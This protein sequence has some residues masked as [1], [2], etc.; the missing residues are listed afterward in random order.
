[1]R[2]GVAL[3]GLVLATTF[4][5]AEDAAKVTAEKLRPLQGIW[6]TQSFESKDAKTDGGGIRIVVDG[7][8]ISIPSPNAEKP[9]K[10]VALNITSDPMRIDFKFDRD[11]G[12]IVSQGIF[13]IEGDVL[14]VCSYDGNG[15][16]RP[17]EFATASDR[18]HLAI[19]KR[20]RD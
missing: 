4:V 2:D 8:T 5:H 18:V 11:I 19:Y 3:L 20:H 16:H 1:M 9:A 12:V 17:T 13:K 6:I 15:D 10:I 7:D 14:T